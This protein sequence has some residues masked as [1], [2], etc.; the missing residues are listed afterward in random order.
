[1]SVHHP[2]ISMQQFVKHYDQ[3]KALIWVGIFEF[4]CKLT[5]L[6]FFMH[7]CLTFRPR[8]HGGVRLNWGKTQDLSFAQKW[9]PWCSDIHFITF[10]HHPTL[11]NEKERETV[12]YNVDDFYDSLLQ[13]INKE[14]RE[15]K[16]GQSVEILEEPILIETYASLSSMI[17]NQSHLGFNRERGGVSY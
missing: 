7:V 2:T 11:Y 6:F 10:T 4:A 3:G 5:Y 14:Y 17:F 16:P 15:Q 13:Q 1:M 9:N 8:Q 12:T